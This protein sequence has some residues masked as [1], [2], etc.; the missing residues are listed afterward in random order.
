MTC[1]GGY[2]YNN[3]M[4]ADFCASS[5]GP[6]GKDGNECPAFC[7]VKCSPKDLQC[8]VEKDENDC[9]KPDMCIPGPGMKLLLKMIIKDSF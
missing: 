4:N 1:P 3:C 7:P 5:K 6:I 9:P 2:G 8:W